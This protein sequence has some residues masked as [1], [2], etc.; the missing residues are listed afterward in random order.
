MITGQIGQKLVGCHAKESDQGRF[1]KEALFN[2]S[3]H[4]PSGAKEPFAA[5]NVKKRFIE[6]QRLNERCPSFKVLL[7][8]EI[9]S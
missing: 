3:C 4:L 1:A 8:H 9:R 6:S 2:G 5:A 7:R